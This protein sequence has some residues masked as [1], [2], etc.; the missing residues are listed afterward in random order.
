MSMKSYLRYEPKKAFGIIASPQSNVSYD[1]SGNLAITGA[2]QDVCVWNLRQAVQVGF[3]EVTFMRS[4]NF[5][6]R[7]HYFLDFILIL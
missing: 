2:A 6:L 3:R 5:S 7:S 1:F 4:W